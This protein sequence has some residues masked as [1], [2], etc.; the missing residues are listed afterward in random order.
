ME[1]EII[2][3]TMEAAGGY[4][5]DGVQF[6]GDEYEMLVDEAKEVACATGRSIIEVLTRMVGE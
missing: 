1:I 6:M 3:G 4:S 2:Q 5:I